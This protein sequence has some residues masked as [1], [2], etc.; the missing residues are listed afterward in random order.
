MTKS[1]I[2]HLYLKKR[3]I[4]LQMHKC[5]PI[6]DHL[7]EFNKIVFDLKNIDVKIDDEVQT[8]ILMCSLPH[9]FEHFVDT[10]MY[11]RD[12]LSIEDVKVALNSKELKKRVSEGIVESSGE[13]LAVRGRTQEKESDSIGWSRLKSKSRKLKCFH[14]HKT[15]HF[16]KDHPKCR[17]KGN[18]KTFD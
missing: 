15:R 3:L 8:I 6:K 12:T 11:V 18:E 5:M 1:L 13:G 14:C 9:F 2:S 17:G 7:D 10:M 4:T 16:G